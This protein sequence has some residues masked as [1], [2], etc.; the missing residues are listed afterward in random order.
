[1]NKTDYFAFVDFAR[2]LENLENA[3]KSEND[4]YL[5]QP[6]FRY[7]PETGVTESTGHTASWEA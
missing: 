5:L 3:F 6:L 7:N 2:A 4:R 1:M